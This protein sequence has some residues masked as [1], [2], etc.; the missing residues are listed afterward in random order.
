MSISKE[1]KL[2]KAMCYALRHR[3]DEFGLTL[4]KYGWTSVEDLV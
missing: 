4:D 3:P 2:S 1:I